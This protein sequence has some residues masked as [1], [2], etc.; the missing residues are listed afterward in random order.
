MFLAVNT[1]AFGMEYVDDV[2]LAQQ[3]RVKAMEYILRHWGESSNPAFGF[4][5]YFAGTTR[6]QYVERMIRTSEF[7]DQPEL[8]ALAHVLDLNIHVYKERDGYGN[9][10][11]WS[12]ARFH[13]LEDTA[14]AGSDKSHSIFLRCKSVHY[15]PYV[16]STIRIPDSYF[17]GRTRSS[18]RD[19]ATGVAPLAS[20]Q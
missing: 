13:A 12:L 9:G 5:H 14:R 8:A 18:Q 10:G 20:K 16:A 17:V 15:T 1:A 4:R 7:G 3:T 19:V 6:E 11:D 2:D